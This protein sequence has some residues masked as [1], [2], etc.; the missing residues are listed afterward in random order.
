VLEALSKACK[1]AASTASAPTGT[2][3]TN[4]VTDAYCSDEKVKMPM[5]SRKTATHFGLRFVLVGVAVAIAA[6]ALAHRAGG[7]VAH[8][9]YAAEIDAARSQAYRAVSTE[10]RPNEKPWVFDGKYPI[11]GVVLATWNADTAANRQ[12]C[13]TAWASDMAYIGFCRGLATNRIVA[14]LLT[15]IDSRGLAY[16]AVNRIAALHTG[17]EVI[18]RINELG[19]DGNIVMLPSL[20]N[21]VRW[22]KG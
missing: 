1:F 11:R 21:V 22:D 14:V 3:V 10:L 13:A 15:G 20:V 9:R 6:A 16:V 12:A 18:V 17:D 19:R 8:P 4:A 2:L 5:N 7:T